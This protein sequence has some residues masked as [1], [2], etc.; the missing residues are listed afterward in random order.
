MKK[1]KDREMNKLEL[2]WR[3]TKFFGWWLMGG[4]DKVKKI[5]GR[6]CLYILGLAVVFFVLG[7]LLGA[8]LQHG[9]TAV[10]GIAGAILFL[11][12]FFSALTWG[13]DL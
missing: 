11:L 12:M 5:I 7:V 13:L 3:G 9:W 2:R 1:H 8:I 6:T 10:F 4:D